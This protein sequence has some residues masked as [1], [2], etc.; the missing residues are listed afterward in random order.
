MNTPSTPRG[1]Q[2]LTKVGVAGLCAALLLGPLSVVAG[3]T[4]SHQV[5]RIT[6]GEFARGKTALTAALARQVNQLAATI[7]RDGVTHVLLEGYTPWHLD[8]PVMAGRASARAHH[9]LAYLGRRLQALGD[10]K[11]HLTDGGAVSGLFTNHSNDRVVVAS[12]AVPGVNYRVTFD[13]NGGTGTMPAESS[14][15]AAVRSTDTF[16]CTGYTFAGWNTAAKGSGMSYADAATYPFSASATLYAEWTAL[17]V[18]TQVLIGTTTTFASTT[19]S[20]ALARSAFASALTYAT[21]GSN[22]DLLVSSNGVVTTANGPLDVGTYEVS[23][24][25]RDALGGTGTWSY[26]LVVGTS[27]LLTQ[28]GGV[29]T[30]TGDVSGVTTDEA[31]SSFTDQLSVSG[32]VGGSSDGC[33]ALV[34]R[35]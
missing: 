25:V 33:A 29:I 23:G 5:K 34:T 9:V 30:Q 6:I 27:G 14:N 28:T 10:A 16:L 35:Y 8:N 1:A 2:L 26:T 18:P 32:A 17:A 24:T 31:S 19:F 3:A 4:A 13:A 7:V 12:F 22:A 15:G 11:V 21:T 20:D